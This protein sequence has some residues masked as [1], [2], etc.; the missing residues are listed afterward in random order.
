MLHVNQLSVTTLKVHILPWENLSY[1]LNNTISINMKTSLLVVFGVMNIAASCPSRLYCSNR[2]LLK[3]NVC[4]VEACALNCT[5]CDTN[6]ASRC[7]HDQCH[8][9]FVFNTV[10]KNCSGE[11]I[12][13]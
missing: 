9:T 4:F 12:H 3:V 6:G 13:L 2:V 11:K 7:D 1:G 8:T 10:D 5:S